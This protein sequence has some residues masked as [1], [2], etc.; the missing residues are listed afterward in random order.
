MTNTVEPPNKGHFGNGCFVLCLE[1]VPISE[2]QLYNPQIMFWWWYNGRESI[3]WTWNHVRIS[4]LWTHAS[5]K[6]LVDSLTA[7]GLVL[8]RLNLNFLTTSIGYYMA[9]RAHMGHAITNLLHDNGM[10]FHR[11]GHWL[12]SKWRQTRLLPCVASCKVVLL[13][14]LFKQDL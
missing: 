10:H 1:V 11:D 2:V 7:S 6:E 14:S 8:A 13:A 4:S 12:L 9:P 5:I 3:K